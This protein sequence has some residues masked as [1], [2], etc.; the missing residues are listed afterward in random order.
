MMPICDSNSQQIQIFFIISEDRIQQESTRKLPKIVEN[1]NFCA[2]KFAAQYSTER[3]GESAWK[4]Y[5]S[6]SIECIFFNIIHSNSTAQKYN[7][8]LSF[9]VQPA[10]KRGDENETFF[11]HFPLIR[12]C[13]SPLQIA[14]KKVPSA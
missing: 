9:F 13:F 2:L 3:R 10:T 11:F 7:K 1:M 4:I 6:T 12:S 8:T 5:G 14:I